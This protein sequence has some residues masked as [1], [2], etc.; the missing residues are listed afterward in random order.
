MTKNQLFRTI[1]PRSLCLEVVKSFGLDGFEDSRN[2]SRKDLIKVNCI[3]KL[4]SLREKLSDYYLPCK[5]RTY[6]N[7][8]N[9][10]NVI[11]LLRQIVRLFGFSVSS[12]EKYIKGDKFIIYQLI[13]TERTD[14]NPIKIDNNFDKNK[15]NVVTFD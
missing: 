8:L 14:Y 12:R 7:G 2:F 4:N 9:S 3:E 11:T 6:L 10:K 1:P 15:N 5:A 13:P